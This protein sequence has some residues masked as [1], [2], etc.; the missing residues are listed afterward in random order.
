[1]TNTGDMDYGVEEGAFAIV[2][3]VDDFGKQAWEQA[4]EPIS[5]G[6]T[7][8]VRPLVDQFIKDV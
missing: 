3:G 6:L 8:Y 5:Y 7:D 1:M 2:E 4:G